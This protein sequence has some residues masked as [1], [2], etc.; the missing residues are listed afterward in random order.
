MQTET[1]GNCLACGQVL[2]EQHVE[3]SLNR[4]CL[5]YAKQPDG[6]VRVELEIM[7]ADV[8]YLF[9][10]PC[11]DAGCAAAMRHEGVA[12]NFPTGP[13]GVCGRCQAPVP[14]SAPHSAYER[15]DGSFYWQAGSGWHCQ[16]S[17]SET[18]AVVCQRCLDDPHW[19]AAAL[20]REQSQQD[21]RCAALEKSKP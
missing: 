18:L 8:L 10:P 17:D 6:Q 20:A 16:P 11:A 2:P 13:V 7:A 21:A 9:C 1:M 4:Q 15:L 3:L 12:V 5:H 14:M 19:P